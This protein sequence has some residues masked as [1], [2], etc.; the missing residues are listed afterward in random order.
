MLSCRW[1]E[2]TSLNCGHQQ[3]YCSCPGDMSMVDDVH[4]GKLPIGS[5]GRSLA[6]LPTEPSSSKSGKSGRRK[7]SI[8]STKYLFNTR[9]VLLHAVKSYNMGPPHLLPLW[10]KACSG[11]L[12]PQ[13]GLN[14]QTLG[15]S[16]LTITP[17]RRLVPKFKQDYWTQQTCNLKLKG[18]YRNSWRCFPVTNN[19]GRWTFGWKH[20]S[21]SYTIRR[22]HVSLEVK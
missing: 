1:G 3:A 12:S 2:T 9:R 19:R 10:K 4:W 18:S 17:L 11:F 21:L 14:P 13:P 7:L 8:L 20:V 15:P 16:T 6:I 22:K 5:P